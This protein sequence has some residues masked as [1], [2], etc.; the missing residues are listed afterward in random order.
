MDAPIV[1]D[2]AGLE[3]TWRPENSEHEFSGPTRFREALVHSL[4][5]CSIRILRQMGIQF[6]LDYVTRFGF[7]ERTLPRNLTF[8]LGTLQATPLEIATGYAVFANGGY[9]VEPY[10]IDRIVNA[11]GTA[12]YAAAPKVVCEQCNGPVLPLPVPPGAAPGAPAAASA[13]ADATPSSGPDTSAAAAAASNGATGKGI[14]PTALAGG[15]EETPSATRVSGYLVSTDAPP[16]PAPDADDAPPALRALAALRSPPDVA[17]DRI[18]T[19]VISAQNA[20]IMD[21][22]MRD[23]ITRG[24]GRRALVLG[25]SDI[26][27]KTGTTNEVKDTWFNGFNRNL[28]ASVWVGFD[29]ERPLGDGEQGARTAVPVWIAFM[30]EA[31]KHVPDKP[32]PLPEG[33]VQAR[34]SP[35]TGQLVDPAEAAAGVATMTETFMADRLPSAAVVGEGHGGTSSTSDMSGGGQPIF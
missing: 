5:L 34:I 33:L 9:R 24:T 32:R 21:D 17:T 27:G 19:R 20:W 31:L 12:V 30:R 18:A 11:A 14:I 25:R 15:P 26:A 8:A 13:T 6:P 3:D 28:V 16:T 23:V 29:Q 35:T 1:M 10:F 22:I 7:D 4:N 2:D